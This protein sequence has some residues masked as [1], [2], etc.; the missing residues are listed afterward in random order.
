MKKNFKFGT[1]M[2]AEGIE[3][4]NDM[5][6]TNSNN[7]DLIIGG[8]RSGKTG[9][10][11]FNLL[12]N[13]TESYVIS[14]TKG[15][16][17]K[18]FGKYLELKG[19]KVQ[20]L[21][22]VNPENSIGYNP[23]EYFKRHSNGNVYERDIKKFAN[24]ITPS[25]DSKDPYWEKAACRYVV[26][27]MAYVTDALPLDEQNIYSVV[28]LH[29][30]LQT[31]EGF[32]IVRDF[33]LENPDT[34]TA[35]KFAEMSPLKNADK[36][37]ACVVDF[38]SEILEPFGYSE[39]KSVFDNKDNI[40][41]NLLG[42]KKSVLFVN[43]SDNDSSFHNVASILYMQI[44]QTLIEQADLHYDGRL[45]VPVRIVLDD[46]A[47][48]P[49]I[50]GFDN[51]I[52]I[53]ASRELSVSIIIQSLSQLNSKYE[54]DIAKT[55]INN[56]DHLLYLS[57]HDDTTADYIGSFIN[58]GKN[59]VLSM[60]K[61]M[62][63]LISDGRDAQMVPKLVPYKDC[64]K[65]AELVKKKSVE[66]SKSK[67]GTAGRISSGTSVIKAKPVNEAVKVVK[68]RESL[69]RIIARARG[70]D[71]EPVTDSDV[72][73]KDSSEYNKMLQDAGLA[74]LIGCDLVAE[75]LEDPYDCWDDEDFDSY[76]DDDEFD[77]EYEEDEDEFVDDECEDGEYEEG[78][79]VK[80]DKITL[81]TASK[82]NRKEE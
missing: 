4:S 56:C 66:N 82:K 25:L 3:V 5:R 48:S 37:W 57:G 80:R 34:F 10:Y 73:V 46:F 13:P 58:K 78:K 39:Y 29:R 44:F 31:K 41:I 17:Y 1:R 15:Q 2:F 64:E 18:I 53:I 6:V 16:L 68:E 45:N 71:E 12:K 9:G 59:T 61:N 49:T 38:A 8:S 60:P 26:M 21:D 50:E 55:I 14:D 70:I 33:A 75:E 72:A 24:L 65:L 32:D 22:L 40:D 81:V 23:F 35:A 19:Y 79:S 28:K 11:I 36:T 62:Q 76:Y 42:E 69:D 20:V 63:I 7:N 54:A 74:D 47:A 77:E 43:V 52:S 27:L 30:L 51:I 67:S